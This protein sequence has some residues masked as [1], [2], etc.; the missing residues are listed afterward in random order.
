MRNG[1]RWRPRWGRPK[2]GRPVRAR[3][4][5]STLDYALLIGVVLPLAYIVMRAA[6]RMMSLVYEM[7]TVLTA[8]PFM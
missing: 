3:R 2:C 4:G 1:P 5:A 6:P 8:W 7:F